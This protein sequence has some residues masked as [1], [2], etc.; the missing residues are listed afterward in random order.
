[1]GGARAAREERE[2]ERE[3][4]GMH[5]VGRGWERLSLW[6]GGEISGRGRLGSARLREVAGL[7]SAHESYCRKVFFCASLI[8]SRVD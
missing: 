6:R 8:E 3:G 4:G 2:G 1:M 5:F 7:G